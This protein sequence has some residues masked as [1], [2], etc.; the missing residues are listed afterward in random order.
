MKRKS[1]RM[2]CPNIAAPGMAFNTLWWVEQMAY[3]ASDKKMLMSLVLTNLALLSLAVRSMF[4]KTARI[5]STSIAFALGFLIL[6]GLRYM[7]YVVHRARKCSLNSLPLSY[8][9][10]QQQGYLLN[11]H[12]HTRLLICADVI[13]KISV[14][15]V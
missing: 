4:V 8:I 2:S 15:L 11:Q 14:F 1:N 3:A 6:V 7:P 10:Y 9:K 12:V 5:R 13:S